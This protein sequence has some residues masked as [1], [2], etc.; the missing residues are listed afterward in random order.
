M[1]PEQAAL[2]LNE[3]SIPSTTDSGI[4]Q[5]IFTKAKRMLD[6]SEVIVKRASSTPKDENDQSPIIKK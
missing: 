3:T 1:T 4:R 5:G 2:S 6:Y